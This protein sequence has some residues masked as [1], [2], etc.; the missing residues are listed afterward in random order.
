MAELV[1]YLMF[2]LTLRYVVVD[3]GALRTIPLLIAANVMV[4]FKAILL[5]Q[6]NTGEAFK[7]SETI[8]TD[9]K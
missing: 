8:I 7:I 3:T 2:R 5:T 6:A 1:V 9:T 4:E